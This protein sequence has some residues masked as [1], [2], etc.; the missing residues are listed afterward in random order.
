MIRTAWDLWW[1]AWPLRRLQ[2]A[3]PSAAEPDGPA[4]EAQVAAVLDTLE[5]M[6]ER[7]ARDVRR[8]FLRDVLVVLAVAALLAVGVLLFV[9][10]SRT[11][12]ALPLSIVAFAAGAG[13]IV[14]AR[15]TYYRRVH[16]WPAERWPEEWAFTP[17]GAAKRLIGYRDL[18]RSV[19]E[20][21]ASGWLS[22]LTC[23]GRPL[24][25]AYARAAWSQTPEWLRASVDAG[26]PAEEREGGERE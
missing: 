25:G 1:A 17:D 5:A 4:D 18:F 8:S 9:V 24:A 20:E 6:L 19:A 11:L 23:D 7:V 26:P 16:T 3:P 15:L 21:D 10:S 14:A 2:L 22:R 12:A 13:A